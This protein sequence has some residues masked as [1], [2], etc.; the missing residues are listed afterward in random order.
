MPGHVKTGASQG[1]G[2]RES[3]AFQC[4]LSDLVPKIPKSQESICLICHWV[5]SPETPL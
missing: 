5:L 2:L 4:S 3:L 1:K